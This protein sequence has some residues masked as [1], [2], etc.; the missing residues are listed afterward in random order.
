MRKYQG[1]KK[2]G[3]LNQMQPGSN[4]REQHGQKQIVKC[5]K[6]TEGPV[7]TVKW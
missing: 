3:W 1:A 2:E 6:G 4:N 5:S 7:R